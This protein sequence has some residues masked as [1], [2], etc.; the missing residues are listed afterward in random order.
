MTCFV[1]VQ[2]RPDVCQGHDR[3]TAHSGR[4]FWSRLASTCVLLA[5]I[6]SP[7]VAFAAPLDLNLRGF[8]DPN[9]PPAE[10]TPNGAYSALMS[11]MALILGSKMVGPGQSLGAL[12]MEAA[13]EMSFVQTNS[14]ADYWKNSVAKPASTVATTQMRVRKGLPYAMQVGAVLT[15]LIDSNLWAIG[16]ELNMS[17]VDGYVSVPDLCLRTS[18][19]SV[20]GHS[21]IS[22]LI[23]GADL[24]LSKSFGVGGV[25]SLQPWGAY[26]FNYSNVT[27][28]QLEVYPNDTTLEPDLE[29]LKAVNN[30][31]HRAAFGMRLVVTHVSIGGEFLR[32]FTDGLSVFTGKISLDF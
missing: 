9:R 32:S 11:E 27:T 26:S 29:L 23:V 12:G 4:R 3:R 24:V 13:L 22:M 6:G 16:A 21:D 2:G 25:L 1:P 19:Q 15:H 5:A 17:L 20:L 30:V 10:A 18:V 7:V 28:R 14:T 31:S 8:Y